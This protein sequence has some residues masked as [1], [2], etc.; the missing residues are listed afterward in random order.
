MSASAGPSEIRQ[1]WYE[2]LN[3]AALLMA[4]MGMP[5]IQCASIVHDDCFTSFMIHWI[6]ETVSGSQ[7]PTPAAPVSAPDEGRWLA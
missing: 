4:D 1:L 7:H 5:K 2:C 6:L 3:N